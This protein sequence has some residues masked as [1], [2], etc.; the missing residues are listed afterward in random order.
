MSFASGRSR[1]GDVAIASGAHLVGSLG[2]F[3]VL[4]TQVL[5][6]Q[7]RGATGVEVAVLVI[8]EALPM[9]VL[10][11][12]IGRLVDRADSRVLLVVAGGAQAV[13][14]LALSYATDLAAILA[15]VLALSAASA[16]WMPTHRALLAAMVHRDDLPRASAIG[17]SAGTI[18]MMAGPALAG[19]LVGGIGPHATV[20]VAAAGFVVTVVAAFAIRT[21]RGG[22]SAAAPVSPTVG[23]PTGFTDEQNQ[24]DRTVGAAV[25]SPA[26]AASTADWTLRTDPLLRACIW[27]LAGV[28][29][30]ASAV[31]VVL[32]FFVMGTLGSPPEAYGVI[33]SMWILGVLAG[34]W[35]GGLS[36][37]P[38]TGDQTVALRLLLSA[39]LICAA[40]VA[41]GSVDSPWWIVP[42]YLVGGA[43]N[44]TINVLSGTLIG[45]RVPQEALGRANTAAA[46]RVQGGALVG[47][48]AG[49]LLLAVAQ[50]RWIVLGCGVLG[51][52]TTA[53]LLPRLR[54]VAE[55]S[56]S[57][58]ALTRPVAA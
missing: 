17:Q 14:C 52:L 26:A 33:D 51:L 1:W 10:G 3:L 19:F 21:R 37:R 9:V 50:P 48:V 34:A 27:S 13:A 47:Y 54:R 2:T 42:C 43:A 30:A 18:G 11:R 7:Q 15:G 23:G 46:V 35:L 6:F 45:R 29:T 38:A 31:N 40:I 41:T 22:R 12:P 53:V 24:P 8:C 55:R 44:G 58:E 36:V 16:V 32:V 5:A 57:D 4:V 25:I 39:G 28:I 56:E 20:R 49:G